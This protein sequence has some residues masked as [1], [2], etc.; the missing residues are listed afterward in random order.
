MLEFDPTIDQRPKWRSLVLVGLQFICAATLVLSA[1][2][3]AILP[4]LVTAL[5][6]SLGTWA[7]VAIGHRR[8]SMMPEIKGSTQ[9]VTAGPY[10]V[11]RHPMYAA[12]LLFCA[13]FIFS[14]FRPWKIGAWLVLVFVLIAKSRI[15][16]RQLLARFPQYADYAQRSW[17]FLPG[18]W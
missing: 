1:R 2:G 11:L 15:E 16:E 12:L 3:V 6:A 7:I 5:G 10:R 13:G 17:R 14:P 18:I 4:M 8:V 9:L